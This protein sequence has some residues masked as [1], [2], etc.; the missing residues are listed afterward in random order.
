MQEGPS[1]MEGRGGK[2]E[3]EGK[4]CRSDK[5]VAGERIG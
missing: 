2:L 5:M 4:E 3:L 1:Q